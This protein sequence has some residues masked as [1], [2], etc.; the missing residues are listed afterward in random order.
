MA[1]STHEKRAAF[2]D[3]DG[4]LLPPPSLE[5]RFINYLLRRGELDFAQAARWLTEFLVRAAFDFQSATKGNKAYLAGL[6]TSLADDWAGQPEREPIKFF[7]EGL[8]LLEWHAAQGHRIFLVSG[9]LAPLAFGIAQR[10]PVPAE[11]CA[12]ELEDSEGCWTGRI[13]G[14]LI[15]GEAKARAIKRLT[16]KNDLDR[17]FS[18]AYGDCLTDIPMLK[19]VGHPA[20]M[21]PS[22][23]LGRVACQRGWPVLKWRK[24]VRIEAS[25]FSARRMLAAP[26]IW[27][28]R[29]VR[30]Q[31]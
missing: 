3:L 26:T 29:N 20:A 4:T 14:E 7:A 2:F 15:S 11:V 1:M 8:E 18:Y 23:R 31:R 12:T 19:S 25:G 13:R 16:A 30:E 17:A 6:P 5:R 27:P 10:L 22:P 28:L 24:T 21:N 9:T